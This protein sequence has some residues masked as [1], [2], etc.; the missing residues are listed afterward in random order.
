[1]AEFDSRDV[2]LLVIKNS[3]QKSQSPLKIH[4]LTFRVIR[5]EDSAKG[6]RVEAITN[7]QKP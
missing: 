1:M 7:S 5:S 4:N 6:E 2:K 3:E